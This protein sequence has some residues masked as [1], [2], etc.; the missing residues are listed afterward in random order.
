VPDTGPIKVSA[1]DLCADYCKNESAAY[2]KYEITGGSCVIAIGDALKRLKA[3]Q[4]VRIWGYCC[5]FDIYIQGNVVVI[6]NYKLQK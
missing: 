1:S 2:D 4:K 6:E 3:G 5:G